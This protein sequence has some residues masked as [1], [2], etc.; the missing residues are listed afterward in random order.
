MREESQTSSA[1]SI[2]RRR[3]CGAC[4]E[5]DPARPLAQSTPP[6]RQSKTAAGAAAAL[7]AAV[8]ET[9]EER[10]L[11]AVTVTEGFP[12]FFEV[13]GDD[14]ANNI[15][16][17]VNQTDQTILV[18]G[19][20][21]FENVQHVTVNGYGGND[22]ISVTNSNGAGVIGAAVLAGAGDDSVTMDLDGG[23]WGGD[24]N[25]IIRLTDSFRAEA[26]GEAGDDSIFI[27]GGCA[28]AEIRGG[29]GN[30][31]IDCTSST[32]I[33]IAYGDAGNDTLYGSK[34]AD[35]LYGGTGSDV[36]YSGPGDIT[37]SNLAPGHV[38]KAA[39]R[40][41]ASYQGDILDGG[42]DADAVFLV[43]APGTPAISGADSIDVEGCAVTF[44]RDIAD[45]NSPSTDISISGGATVTFTTTQHLGG[46][47]VDDGAVLVQQDGSL[48]LNVQ[49]I[50]LSSESRIDL[51]DNAMVIRAGSV[52]TWDGTGYTDISGYIASGRNGGTWDG[53]GI[54]TSMP[55]AIDPSI[56]TTLGIAS[57]GDAMQLSTGQTALWQGQTVDANAVLVRYTR[58]GDANLDGV[59]DGED[60]NNID[61]NCPIGAHGYL[62]G[63][64][65]YDGVINGD[66]YFIIDSNL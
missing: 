37:G 47:S 4:S 66:D 58:S 18:A 23:V 10:R 40:A 6:S 41:P 32:V 22:T 8:L 63:D 54:V 16:V 1:I 34:F 27:R 51:A 60:H 56:R 12:G 46:L 44:V 7:E 50:D 48:V 45:L 49:T 20:G 13:N 55:D 14:D 62:Q 33:V 65:N 21:S 15:D 9:L 28:D 42:D 59:I 2:S 25:D 5:A 24:G 52:G 17:Q 39:A 57:A 31:V 53:D 61:A 26:Y 3:K 38:R 29:D 19:V 30:D 35:Q 11:F 64:F 43:D 36:L